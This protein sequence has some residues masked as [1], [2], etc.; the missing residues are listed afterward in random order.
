MQTLSVTDLTKYYGAQRV[1][2][3]IRFH[4]NEG[5]RL[6]I[7]GANGVGKSTLIRIIAGEVT[8]D[9]GRVS[10]RKDADR[11][12]LAQVQT[13]DQR[14]TLRDWLYQALTHIHDLERQMRA[15]EVAMAAGDAGALDQYGDVAHR[16]ELLGGYDL[17]ARIDIVFSGLGI[18][19]LDRERRVSSF[20][21]GETTR[22]ALALLLLRSPDL[23]LL[24]EPTNHLDAAAL[25][26]L[27]GYLRRHHGSALVVSHDREFLNRTVNAILEI[28]EHTRSARR[29]PGDYDAYRAQ[30]A[31]ERQRWE[32]DY[33]AQQ[34]EI[35]TLQIEIKQGARRNDNYRAHTDGDKLLRNAKIANHESTVSK[36]V[37]DAETRLA[38]LL[39]D[40][41]PKPPKPLQFDADFDPALMASHF[42]LRAQGITKSYSGRTIL[43]DVSFD[44]PNSARI[45]ITGEN[46]VGKSTLLRILAGVEAADAGSVQRAPT[47]QIGYMPQDEPPQR[48]TVYDVFAST[49]SGAPKEIMNQLIWTGLFRF[50]EVETEVMNLS[51]GQR[52]KLTLARL[53]ASRANLLLLDEP[54][55]HLSPDVL[56]EL[57]DALRS[58]P[59]TIIAIS[60]DRRFLEGFRGEQWEVRDNQIWR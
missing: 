39:R 57:E 35:K 31:V 16:Y 14:A 37:R 55:N 58:F 24:D 4:L 30:K 36:R 50:D 12:Y 41:I 52:R 59:G 47:V 23:L 13:Q 18:A 54:T 33:A 17:D 10:I 48:G 19:H 51:A 27:E 56:E 53:M 45:A 26:W 20:S 22:I 60:H 6:G 28:D 1:L 49:A 21:G 8:A 7:V 3:D 44:I 25:E 11:G 32:Q 43:S 38:H 29:F 9:Q 40:P 5:E 15:L 46:G 42:A 34:D 2:N